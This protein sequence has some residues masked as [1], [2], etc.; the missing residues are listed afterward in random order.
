MSEET[1]SKK[2]NWFMKHKILTA[3]LALILLMVIVSAASGGSDTSDSSSS[4][5]SES[6]D[7]ATAEDS[8]RFEDRADKQPED[9][10][11]LPGESATVEGVKMTLS[12]VNYNA[13]ISEF[14]TADSGMT[15]LVANVSLVNTSEDTQPYNIFD[16]RVQ[17]AGGQV[18][19]GAFTLLEGTLG[20]GDLVSGGTVSGKIVF[21]VPVE[22]GHQYV[23]WKPNA[24][25]AKRAIVQVK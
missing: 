20:S 10:E 25:D 9:V 1:N 4:E 16:Y 7:S 21:E 2:Q 23:I 13:S 22:E 17:T 12:D 5:S 3:I 18:L 6:A 8:F 19:D 24:F 14:D 11:V 15:Y